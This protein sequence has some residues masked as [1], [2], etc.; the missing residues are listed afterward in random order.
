MSSR[1]ILHGP[2]TRSSDKAEPSIRTPQRRVKQRGRG[3]G[4]IRKWGSDKDS[5]RSERQNAFVVQRRQ[6]TWEYSV[7]S[8]KGTKYLFFFLLYT[9]V[10]ACI[11]AKGLA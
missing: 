2:S 10:S 4:W 5:R 6:A 11:L 7:N 8:A 1:P 3:S 9:G